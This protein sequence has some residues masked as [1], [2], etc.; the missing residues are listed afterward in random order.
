MR[1]SVLSLQCATLWFLLLLLVIPL[2]VLVLLRLVV[3][4]AYALTVPTF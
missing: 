3:G 4:G 2:L 1:K